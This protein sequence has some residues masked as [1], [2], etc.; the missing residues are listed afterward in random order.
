[1]RS[2]GAPPEF[3]D[4]WAP[5]IDERVRRLST[6]G[7]HTVAYLYEVPDTSTFRYRVFNMV[8]ALG[9]EDH[10]QRIS[11][12]WFT[13]A[14]LP[15]LERLIDEVRTLVICR[16][17]Y[18]ARLDSLV[19]RARAAGCRVL[20]DVDDLIFDTR[21]VSLVLETL[22]R[23]PG[24]AMLDEW[25]ASMSRIGALL[26]LCD[27]AISTNHFL[28]A[29]IEDFAQLPTW[30]VP[31]F[32]NDLQLE[33]AA[34]VRRGRP[35]SEQPGRVTTIGYFS[36]TPTHNRDFELVSTALARVMIRHADVRLRIVGFLDVGPALRGFGDRIDI[37]PLTDFLTLETL[38]G[39]TGLNVVPLQTNAF[40]NSKSELKYFEAAIVET[41][42]F[43]TP[44][45]SFRLA[46]EDGVNGYLV[47]S[48]DW[49]DRLE[50]AVCGDLDLAGVAERGLA[51]TL[52]WYTPAA[53]V[54]AIRD[55]VLGTPVHK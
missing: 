49:E 51:H 50:Q 47:D 27:G 43:A 3:P 20:F 26:R 44:T 16:T 5:S 36:G 14:E 21:Y 53:Q 18:T 24:E 28:S 17:R 40:S 38:I 11:A 42:T 25:F 15:I 37:L 12:T 6:P 34:E 54:G 8:E 1:M 48:Y 52:R 10:S 2:S 46:I 31:N 33:R 9:L 45:Y 32:L 41:P 35:A 30:V 55:A 39:A 7:V 13:R 23:N 22:D 19:T 29:R 4:P